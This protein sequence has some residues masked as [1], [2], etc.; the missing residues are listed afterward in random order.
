M[1]AL[2]EAVPAIAGRP[3]LPQLLLEALEATDKGLILPGLAAGVQA[4]VAFLPALYEPHHDGLGFVVEPDAAP[5]FFPL[6]SS[7]L[8]GDVV[9]AALGLRLLDVADGFSRR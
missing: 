5:R 9:L 3:A 1:Q 4:E 6:A 8:W 2:G 7:F